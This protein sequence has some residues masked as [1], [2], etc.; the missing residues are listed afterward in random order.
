M[1]GLSFS[2]ELDWG[3]YL[4]LTAETA[5]KIGAL[6]CSMKLLCPEMVFIF[7]NLLYGLAW[8]AVVISDLMLDELQNGCIGL[9]VLFFCL[10]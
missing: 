10:T 9:V 4:V 5:K 8:N 3:S 2:S 6:I 7:I 1:L